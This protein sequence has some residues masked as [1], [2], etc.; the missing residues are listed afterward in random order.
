MLSNFAGFYC[1]PAQL[2]ENA[3]AQRPIT[4]IFYVVALLY[5][6][7]SIILIRGVQHST[8]TIRISTYV[9]IPVVALIILASFAAWSFS[10]MPH[11]CGNG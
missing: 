10:S 11:L 7:L 9:L 3:N 2:A 5:V 6:V 8:K 1:E 4:I